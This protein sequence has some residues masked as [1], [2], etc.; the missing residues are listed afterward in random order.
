MYDSLILDITMRQKK[1]LISNKCLNCGKDA[2]FSICEGK[3]K[4]SRA[5][6]FCSFS[7]S[8]KFNSKHKIILS[9]CPLCKKQF[10]KYPDGTGRKYCSMECF[11]TVRHKNLP[12]YDYPKK[13]IKR[14]KV[15]KVKGKQIYLHRWVMEKHLGRKLSRSEVVHH[16]NGDP[17]DNRVENLMVMS[18]SE[19]KT[20]EYSEL[21]ILC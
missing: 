20:L 14:Y 18:Q 2:G 11:D 16:I 17:H 21:R 4:Q 15:K 7:C 8:G 1:P 9:T 13:E 6:K 10:R 12:N 5:R 19:H 3:V